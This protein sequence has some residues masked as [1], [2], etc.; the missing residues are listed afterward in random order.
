MEG[1]DYAAVSIAEATDNL[2]GDTQEDAAL[3]TGI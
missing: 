1:G 2:N 3:N